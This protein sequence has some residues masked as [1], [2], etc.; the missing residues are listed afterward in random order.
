MSAEVDWVLAQFASV[1]DSVAADYSITNQDGS[2]DP[3]TLKRIDRDDSEIL[4][5]DMRDRTAELQRGCY[6]GATDAA[7]GR[8]PI[9]FEYDSRVEPVVGVRVEGL[10]HDEWGH[11]DPDGTDGVPFEVLVRRLRRAVQAERHYPDVSKPDTSFTT[12]FVENEAPQSDQYADY[13]RTD[14]DVRFRGYEELPDT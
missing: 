8:E 6:V 7:A 4:E 3:V 13:Y 14:F 1:V 12:L 5:G 9:G 10:H 11:V 2:T